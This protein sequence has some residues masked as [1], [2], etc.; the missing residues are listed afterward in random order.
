MQGA[1][2]LINFCTRKARGRDIYLFV[3]EEKP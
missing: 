1:K 3:E 2:E